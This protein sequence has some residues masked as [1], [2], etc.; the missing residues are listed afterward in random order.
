MKYIKNYESKKIDE[1]QKE[2]WN[3]IEPKGIRLHL[4]NN[5]ISY[6]QSFYQY[7]NWLI[8]KINFI[9]RYKIRKKILNEIFNKISLKSKNYLPQEVIR[10]VLLFD[11]GSEYIINEKIEIK[12]FVSS[13]LNTNDYY[14]YNK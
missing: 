12:S 14:E 1:L 5:I 2:F 7:N 3:S 10:Y 13:D 8:R 9:N 6:S 4:K 11:I